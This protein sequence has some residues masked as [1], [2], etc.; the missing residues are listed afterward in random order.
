MEIKKVSSQK[1]GQI[2]FDSKDLEM[3]VRLGIE[4]LPKKDKNKL[5][6]GHFFKNER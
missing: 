1:F 2:Y 3:K 4:D 5:P 6:C